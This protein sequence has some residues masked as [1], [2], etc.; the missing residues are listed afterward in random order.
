MEEI[1]WS[2]GITSAM[3]PEVLYKIALKKMPVAKC[4]N[5]RRKDRSCTSTWEE[6]YRSMD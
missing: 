2:K 4:V 3:R 5:E 1:K 6:H